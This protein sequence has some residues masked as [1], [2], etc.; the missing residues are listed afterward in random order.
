MLTHWIW[1]SQ[2]PGLKG[3][4]KLQLLEHFRSPED[5][6]LLQKDEIRN[7]RFLGENAQLG[8]LNKDL[9][10]ASRILKTCADKKIGVLAFTDSGF[11]ERLRRIDDPPMVLYYLG[12]LPAWELQPLIGIVGTRNAST[13]GLRAAAN[14]SAQIAAC[15]GLVVS[16]GALGI[17]TRALEGALGQGKSTV[18]VLAGGLDSFYPKSNEPLFRKIMENGC[19]LSENPPGASAR[20]WDFLHRNRLISGI[21]NGVLVVEAPEASGALNTARWASEQGREVFAVPGNIDV[22]TCAGSNAL[23][24]EIAE[25]AVNGWSVMSHYRDIYPDTVKKVQPQL[26]PEAMPG[27]MVAQQSEKPTLQAKADKIN[28]D[29]PTVSPYSVKDNVLSMLSPQEKAIVEL[30]TKDPIPVDVV[31]EK[32]QLPSGTVLSILTKLAVKGVVKNHP[33]KLISLN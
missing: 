3:R 33:G 27:P 11:P 2:L 24:G 25:A 7:L 14:L 5:I 1:F 12:K 32:L 16:G 8:I 13:Y 20:K 15:G 26:K 17:D 21:S 19:V 9:T 10:Q 31:M 29:K 28:V 4:Q 23:I 18:A 22:E 6:Y 30:L